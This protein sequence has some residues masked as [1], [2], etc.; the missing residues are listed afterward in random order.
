MSKP[1]KSQGGVGLKLNRETESTAPKKRNHL[2]KVS[3]ETSSGLNADTT[4]AGLRIEEQATLIGLKSVPQTHRTAD[5]QSDQG[6]RQAT[7]KGSTSIPS[8]ANATASASRKRLYFNARTGQ[9]TKRLHFHEAKRSPVK[10]AAGSAYKLADRTT[11]GGGDSVDPS[12][13][14][15]RVTETCARNSVYHAASG[16]KKLHQRRKLRNAN[17]SL[18][19]NAPAQTHENSAFPGSANPISK[20]IQ[21]KN[22]QKKYAAAKHGRFAN[23][24]GPNLASQ[25]TRP[26]SVAV[27]R[28]SKL[29]GKAKELVHYL[30]KKLFG[31]VALVACIVL[32]PIILLPSCGMVMGGSTGIIESMTYQAEDDAMLAA[33]AAY[34][35]MEADLQQRLNNYEGQHDYDEYHFELDSIEHDPYVLISMLCAAFP[36]AW[37]LE[38]V[39]PTLESWFSMQYTLTET[40]VEEVRETDPT[41]PTNPTEPVPTEPEPTQPPS[42]PRPPGPTPQPQSQDDITDGSSTSTYTI[43]TVT[44]KNFN[45][46]HIPVYIFSQEQLETYSTYMACLGNREDL[47][48]DSAY[49]GQY[50]EGSYMDY[51]I[52]TEALDDAVFAAMMTEARKYLGYPYVWG[53]STPSTSFDCSGFVSWVINHTIVNGVPYWG[54]IG[55]RGAYGLYVYCTPTSTPHPGDLVF[56]ENT[57][58]ATPQPP[59]THVGIYVGVNPENGHRMM[60]HCGDPISFADLSSSYWTEHLYGYGHIPDP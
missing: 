5:L 45:L 57:Y 32:L 25:A 31:L 54:D 42:P 55:R 3:T 19:M 6:L 59:C 23:V 52:P 35:E 18:K 49:I 53:G 14:S 9:T 40:V 33:E 30:K 38:E 20:R 43:C 37:T 26:G 17:A 36:G 27:R 21:K 48:P 44:L 29:A 12:R 22:I 10:Q 8:K 46:S 39:S 13:E 4:G 60:I 2:G 24:P 15:L 34:C 41:D 51:S 50:G 56:F 16:S 7:N 28:S 47:F 11:P 1:V 58:S